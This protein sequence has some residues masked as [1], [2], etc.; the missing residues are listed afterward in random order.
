M[1]NFQSNYQNLFAGCIM[2]QV[3]ENHT[4]ESEF[5][6]VNENSCDFPRIKRRAKYLPK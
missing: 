5:L 4:N 2:V 6:M 3:S 1:L